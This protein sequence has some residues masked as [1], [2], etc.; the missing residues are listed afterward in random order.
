MQLV[1]VQ[2][3]YPSPLALYLAIILLQ[4]QIRNKESSPLAQA[5]GLSPTMHLVYSSPLLLAK[6]FLTC[7]VLHQMHWNEN[8]LLIFQI[9]KSLVHFE[10]LTISKHY[11]HS[12]H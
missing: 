5:V 3:W 11:N 7:A 9:C 4:C 12:Y 6:V 10:M 2:K 8:K 1:L